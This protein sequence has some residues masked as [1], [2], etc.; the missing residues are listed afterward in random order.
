[1]SEY[2]F[3]HHYIFYAVPLFLTGSILALYAFVKLRNRMPHYKGYLQNLQQMKE[4][5]SNAA[6]VSGTRPK[7]RELAAQ[8]KFY[9]KRFYKYKNDTSETREA[10][11]REV[12]LFGILH[13]GGLVIIIISIIWSHKMYRSTL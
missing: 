10:L 1:M 7:D 5:N 6:L 13:V 8:H 11:T 2:I 3:T 4:L 12:L 9:Q